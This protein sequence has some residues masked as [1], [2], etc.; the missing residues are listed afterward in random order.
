[1][2]CGIIKN[3]KGIHVLKD[4]FLKFGLKN[5]IRLIPGGIGTCELIENEIFLNQLRCLS[6]NLEYI[7]TVFTGSILFSKTG[8]LNFKKATT[9]KQVFS[10]KESIN[11]VEWIQKA[12]R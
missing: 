7:S 8:L 4:S 3:I 2:N 6:I 5:H 10:W 11:E 12:R 1:M 9:N